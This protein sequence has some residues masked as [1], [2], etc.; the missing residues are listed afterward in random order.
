MSTA[1]RKLFSDSPRVVRK[2]SSLSRKVARLQRQVNS[3]KPEVRQLH[4]TITLTPA[5]TTP[6]PIIL[7]EAVVGDEIKLH[8]VHV[9]WDS[10]SNAADSQEEIPWG[11]LYSPNQGYSEIDCL[12]QQQGSQIH[13]STDNYKW[14]FDST[15]ARTWLRKKQPLLYNPATPERRQDVFE[16]D[17]RFTFPMIC[18]TDPGDDTVIT[19]N[20]IY[21]VTSAVSEAGGLT[22]TLY[23]TLWYTDS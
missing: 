1:K 3:N 4:Y 5:R 18:G 21:L 20:Q 12:P 7:P 14:I 15:R 16:M 11:V 9:A 22:N 2:P 13:A 17:K 19:R 23:I 10:P 8:R 6:V